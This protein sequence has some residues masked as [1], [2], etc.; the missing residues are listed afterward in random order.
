M[1]REETTDSAKVRLVRYAQLGSLPVLATMSIS[2]SGD[3]VDQGL[4]GHRAVMTDAPVYEGDFKT[5]GYFTTFGGPADMSSSSTSSQVVSL[6][7]PSRSDRSSSESL[8]SGADGIRAGR[9]A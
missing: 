6:I 9:S 3:I 2:A 1:P 4:S 7:V 8:A 5:N